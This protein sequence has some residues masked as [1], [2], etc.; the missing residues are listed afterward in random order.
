[1]RC[2][3]LETHRCEI[4]ITNPGDLFVVGGAEQAVTDL[5]HEAAAEGA[6]RTG[7]LAVKIAS[8]TAQLE[9]ACEPFR[10]ALDASRR[11]PIA[12]QYFLLAGGDGERI[13][14]A[15]DAMAKLARQVARPIDWSATLQAV[16]QLGV[17]K[18]WTW[19]RDMHCGHDAGLSTIHPMLFRRRISHGGW[20][21]KLDRV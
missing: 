12:S 19:A 3:L 9:R 17:S 1:M 2:N 18:C 15:S 13:F 16:V 6:A 14:S 20:L 11:S 5:C 21:A 4:A 10:Q 8:H 7:L